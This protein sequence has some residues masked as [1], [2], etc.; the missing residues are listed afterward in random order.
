[1]TRNLSER[2][3]HIFDVVFRPSELSEFSFFLFLLS[4]R[5][6]GASSTFFLLFSPARLCRRCYNKTKTL[7]INRT[8]LLLP[9]F[10]PPRP[11]MHT[12]ALLASTALG[13][14]FSK[15]KKR[16]GGGGGGGGELNRPFL[17]F[18]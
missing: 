7:I 4:G 6:A 17:P 5:G 3:F 14:L 12:L 1:M 11:C 9:V 13:S 16:R 2:K 10:F 15:K 8:V 18:L